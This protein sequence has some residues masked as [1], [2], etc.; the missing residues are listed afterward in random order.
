[1]LLGFFNRY[2]SRMWDADPS[3]SPTPPAPTPPTPPTPT[4]DPASAPDPKPAG[5]RT[6]T[7]AE[8]EAAVKAQLAAALAAE[9]KQQKDKEAE[10]Q[11]KFKELAEQR[12]QEIQAKAAE[13]E[14]L[15]A[16]AEAYEKTLQGQL[17]ERLKALPKPLAAL[18]TGATLTDRMAALVNAEAAAKE[19]GATPRSPGTPSGPNNGGARTQVPDADNAIVEAKLRT[20]AYNQF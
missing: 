1:M 20:G 11:G 12:E 18:V 14:Q 6:Y 2:D 4:G 10:A 3:S 16:K 17:D 13:L 8:L 9:R 7:A 5:E 15:K 19:L